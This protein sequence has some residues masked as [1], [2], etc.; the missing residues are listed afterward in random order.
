[1]T[2]F[3]KMHGL[4]NDFV[5]FDARDQAISL[6]PAMV[7]RLADRH[8]GIGCDTVVMIGQGG[9]A[10]DASLLFYNADGGEVESCGNAT[11]CVARLVMD[12]RGLAGVSGFPAAAGCWSASDAGKGDWWQSTWARPGWPG[13]KFPSPRRW[14]PRRSP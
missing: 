4:G 10:A 1:M 2:M 13:M 6:T 3:R 14:T 7:R 8:F 12:E 11:R 9:A 5:V